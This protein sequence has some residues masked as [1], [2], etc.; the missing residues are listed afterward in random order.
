LGYLER[1]DQTFSNIARSAKAK[2]EGQI[3][4]FDNVRVL[5]RRSCNPPPGGDGRLWIHVPVSR[6]I[7]TYFPG[8]AARAIS[9][10]R[11]LAPNQRAR[12]ES[13]PG[14]GASTR[15]DPSVDSPFAPPRRRGLT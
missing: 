14:S 4:A 11:I 3:A 10:P 1:L 7:A 6:E 9:V 12:F 2:R 8:A 15:E 13:L 5:R